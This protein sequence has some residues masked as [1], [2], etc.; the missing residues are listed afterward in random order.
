LEKNARKL[1]TKVRETFEDLG[2]K[3]LDSG[4]EM[5]GG[6][7]AGGQYALF[8]LGHILEENVAYWRIFARLAKIGNWLLVP[9]KKGRVFDIEFSNSGRMEGPL[10][11][12]GA[13]AFVLK[14]W[15]DE[16]G[17]CGLS[18]WKIRGKD[19]LEF[20]ILVGKHLRI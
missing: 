10:T 15:G 3:W 17:R 7:G 1:V 9:S 13:C 14:F 20:S 6:V 5:S 8:E 16:E 12:R 18:I 2:G 19:F 11:V 4:G